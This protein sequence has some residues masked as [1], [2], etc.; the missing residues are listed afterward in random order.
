M[1]SSIGHNIKAP[2]VSGL[3]SPMSGQS[4]KNF[5]WS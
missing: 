2:G 3:R 5:E 1:H 4:V